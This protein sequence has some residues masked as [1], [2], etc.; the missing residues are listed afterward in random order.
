MGKFLQ[1]LR[2]PFGKGLRTAAVALT[3]SLFASAPGA[4]ASPHPETQQTRGGESESPKISISVKNATLEEVLMLLKQKSG[5]YFLYNSNAVRKIS[6]ITLRTSNASVESI[7]NTCLQPTPFEYTIKDGTIVIKAKAGQEKF[8]EQADEEA[9]RKRLL[10]GQVL[11][12]QTKQPLAGVTVYVKGGRHGNVTD[13]EGKYILEFEPLPAPQKTTIVFSFVGME[14]QEVAYTG[15]TRINVSLNESANEVENVVVT[16]YANIRKESFTGNTVSI[17]KEELQKVSKTN[18][19][20]AIQTFDPSFRIKENNNWGSD[21][22][23]LPEVYIRGESGIGTKEM[24]RDQFSKANLKD[25]PNLPIFILDGFQITA[26]K[27]YDMDPNRIENVTILKDAAATAL[28]GSRAANGVVVITSVAPKPGRF[29]IS[30]SMVGDVV[31][32]DLSDYNL[33]NAAE[34]LEVERLAGFYDPAKAGQYQTSDRDEMELLQEYNAKLANVKR[35]VDTYWLSKPLRTAFNHK[36]SIYIDGGSDALRFGVDFQYANQ[37]GVM[38]GSKRDRIGAGFYLQ[39]TYKNVSI[40]N[41]ASFQQTDSEESPYGSFSDYT[42]ALPY[43]EFRDGE[44]KYLETLEGWRL[45]RNPANPLYE[46]G[47]S[48]FDKSRS[49]EFID[50]LSVN[51]NITPYLLVKAQLSLTKIFDDSDVFYDPLSKKNEAILNASNASSGTLRT[52]RGNSLR[53]DM[54]AYISY[55]RSFDKHNLNIQGGVNILDNSSKTTNAT[56]LG[57]PSGSLSSINYAQRLDGKPTVSESTTRSIGF[58]AAANYSYRDIYLFDVSCRLD[59]NSAFGKDKR[60][61]PFWSGGVGLNIHNYEF[62]KDSFVNY[63]KLRATYGQTGKINFPAYAA[64]TTYQVLADE[65]Y[66][67]GFGASLIALGNPNLKWETTNTLDVGFEL[68]FWDNRVFTKFS[69]Y[70]KLT[71]DLINDVTIPSSTGFTTY[72]DNIGEI[73]NR[74]VEVDL[75]VLAVHSKDWFLSINANLAHNKN[76]LTKIA[77]SLQ[78]YNRRVQNTQQAFKPNSINDL[79]SSK[80][81]TQYVEGQ[82]INTIWGMKSLGIDPATG[83]EVYLTRDGRITNTWTASEQQALGVKDPKIQGSF[84]F[85]LVWKQFSLYTSFL[86]EAGG[87]RY[88]Q[89]L[90]D[91][92]EGINI[93][94]SNVDKRVLTDRWSEPGQH[95]KFKKLVPNSLAATKTR[96]TS[97]FVQDYNMLQMSALTLGYDF[98]KSTIAPLRL[99][100]LR[101]ELGATDLFHLSSV[102][103]ERGLSY[104]YARTFTFSIK[105]AF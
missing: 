99:S 39:Y 47:L 57:F 36:H 70:N 58:L 60:F 44:G 95:A 86:Y 63:L 73:T 51:W 17:S 18:V 80:P 27:L 59:G 81:F 41:Y 50:N 1:S 83:E 28:Y 31:T 82:S 104:P 43:N 65:W 42:K 10:L 84:G 13:S 62:M 45:S 92:V 19:M 66:K 76:Q 5:Y 56:Y 64:R 67:T 3:L 37:D 23:A 68:G 91:K 100:M 53:Y 33:T 79:E 69:Y 6:G 38:K 96:P 98:K 49:Q 61:A 12:K 101:L 72:R 32:P 105:A 103:Q 55:N 93:Y 20:K 7:L 97:R 35:G 22:N 14:P 87:Q 29:N 90:A 77:H 4:F 48:N 26:Q 8:V 2:P 78:E 15:Q 40:K 16:G 71:K 34:K 88:N 9:S 89:T 94:S 11:S 25:N 46:A 85:N 102:E 54:N 21:P 24:D 52:G 74:G 75:R 30:Y